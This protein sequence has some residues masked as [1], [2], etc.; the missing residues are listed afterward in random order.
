MLAQTVRAGPKQPLGHA[1]LIGRIR[2]RHP[3]RGMS[4]RGSRFSSSLL[5]WFQSERRSFPWRR[6]RTPYHI[7]VAELFLRKT[8]AKQVAP[9]YAVFVRRFPSVRRLDKARVRQIRSAV[10]SLGLATRAQQL[11]LLARQLM[12]RFAGRVPS[13]EHELLSL[14]GVGTYTASAVLCFAFGQRRAVLD[15]NVI[16]VF[17]RYFGLRSQNSR[18]RTDKRLWQIA[19]GL[20]PNQKHREYNWA[21][22]DFAAKVCRARHPLCSE[23][24]LRKTCWWFRRVK[25]S[26]GIKPAKRP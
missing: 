10:W 4:L 25:R 2:M 23:C 22:L 24:P 5:R 6:S 13:S 16:R 14:A 26:G 17:S 15:A 19:D 20:V 1:I 8:Q 18:P 7:L 11:K 9:I 21:I 12:E 3:V